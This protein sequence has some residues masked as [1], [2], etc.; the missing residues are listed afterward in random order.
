MKKFIILL[1]LL[2]LPLF[3]EQDFFAAP[4]NTITYDADCFDNDTVVRTLKNVYNEIPIITGQAGDL[5]KS[6]VSIWINPLEKTWT[7]VA[8]H[9]ETSCIIGTGINFK[10]LSYSK[11]NTF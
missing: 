8:T 7:I 5:T 2:P 3:A 6:F 4:E 1:F 9:N 11:Q 10:I